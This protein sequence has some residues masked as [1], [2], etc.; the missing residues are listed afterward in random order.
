VRTRFIN[1][2][3]AALGWDVYYDLPGRADQHEVKERD[4]VEVE[5][6]MKNPDYS[7][8][9]FDGSLGS[10]KRK[11]FIEVKRPAVNIES[12]AY[13][14]PSLRLVGRST[15]LHLNQL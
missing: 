2:M 10:M 7:F 9:L 4:S 8:R 15:H 1:P 13:P 12:G 3:I 14:A 6:K 11:F 5:G